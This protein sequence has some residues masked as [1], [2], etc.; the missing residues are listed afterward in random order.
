MT[1][2]CKNIPSVF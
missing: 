1:A 2:L